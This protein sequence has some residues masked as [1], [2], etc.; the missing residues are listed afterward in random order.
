MQESG[1]HKLKPTNRSAEWPWQKEVF[2]QLQYVPWIMLEDSLDTKDALTEARRLLPLF[3][4]HRLESQKG[5]GQWKSLSLKAAGG[6]ADN[7][8]VP[9]PGDGCSYS[10]TEIA[11][12]CPATMRLLDSIT[13]IS[14]C[15][16][17]RFMLLEPG[18]EIIVHSDAPGKP[19]SLALNI[20]MNMPES[21]DFWVDLDPDGS[22]NPYSKKIPIRT[23]SA[24]LF[25]SS[26]YHRVVNDSQEHR[27]HLIAH[28]PIRYNDAELIEKSRA[29]NGTRD[30]RHLTNLL[31]RKKLENGEAIVA[32][33]PICCDFFNF[34]A[35][36]DFIPSTTR[37]ALVTEDL[38]DPSLTREAFLLTAAGL[39]NI[40]HHIVPLPQLQQWLEQQAAIDTSLAVIIAA[41]TQIHDPTTFVTELVKESTRLR[42]SGAGLAGHLIH[43]AGEL[44]Y[45]HGQFFLLD[46]AIWKSAGYPDFLDLERRA[47]PPF[48]PARER[49]HGD[50]TPLWIKPSSGVGLSGKFRFGTAVL[51]AILGRGLPAQNL[52]NDLRAQK[53]FMYPQEGR[54]SDYERVRSSVN[55]YL[56]NKADKVYVYNTEPMRIEDFPFRPNILVTPC[57]GFKPFSLARQF[58]LHSG[59]ARF[60]F[61]EKNQNAIDYY[62]QLLDCD[63]LR[64]VNALQEATLARQGQ[65]PAESRSYVKKM[66]S[67]MLEELFEGS[68]TQFLACLREMRAAAHFE[69]IDYLNEPEKITA[70]L[71][72]EDHILFWHSNVWEYTAAFYEKSAQELRN[73]YISL[74]KRLSDKF[75]LPALVHYDSYKAVLGE[76]FLSPRI[77]LTAGGSKIGKPSRKS[78]SP[79][80]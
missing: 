18:S 73:N 40:P 39:N 33:D 62:R 77:V 59:N 6:Q 28:G 34:G 10:L 42:K 78:F 12:L 2:L 16:R 9:N 72:A 29:Q 56:Q 45:L 7:T 74:V 38:S 79:I 51:A 68:G 69:R 37:I 3:V 26:T 65:L 5:A 64:E 11:T 4:P 80:A 55:R 44:P 14:Q 54:G 23:G 32:S 76:D 43:R 31:M 71:S 27:I 66:T 35:L 21:C 19:T 47:F 22:M 49:V 58:S 50:Y 75:R 41:G 70:L 8:T 63:S 53:D 25:N 1:E 36:F 57:T 61:L 48:E 46:L 30:I 67:A 15:D 60:L 13:D 24:F 17:I 20:A 52:S